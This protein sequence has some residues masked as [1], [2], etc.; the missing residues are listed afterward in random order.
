MTAIGKIISGGQTGV[1]RAALDA[2]I[3]LGITGGGWCPKGRASEQGPIPDRYP[4]TETPSADPA[5]RTERN[6]RDADATLIIAQGKLTGGAALTHRLAT[7]LPKPCLVIDPAEATSTAKVRA[8]LNEHAV[9][10]LN[11][12]GPRAS[13]DPQIYELALQLM[14]KV[15]APDAER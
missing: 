8:W 15:L 5:Q 10:T 7:S 12:A 2:A 11:V 3:E 9:T 1:D 4:L 6:V 13:T 14:R